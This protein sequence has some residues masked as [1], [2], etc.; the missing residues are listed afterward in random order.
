M[1]FYQFCCYYLST[2]WCI[3]GFNQRFTKTERENIAEFSK[4]DGI[5]T[6]L[7][8]LELFFDDVLVDMIV[9]Y[10]KLYSHRE[11]ADTSFEITNE[12]IRLFLSMLLLTRCHNHPDRKMHWEMTPIIFGEQGLIQ[13]FVIRSSIFFGISIFMTTN[14]LI[15]KVN[16][17]ISFP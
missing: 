12:K 6:P 13:C 4:L 10:T 14:N 5:V 8:L 17:R 11:K 9:G 16:S 7:R 1:I 15:N 2:L 3:N